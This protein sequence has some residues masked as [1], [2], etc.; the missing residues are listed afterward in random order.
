VMAAADFNVP[1]EADE[2]RSLQAGYRLKDTQR[3]HDDAEAKRTRLT[4]PRCGQGIE[5]EVEIEGTI[6]CGRHDRAIEMEPDD[7][8]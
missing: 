3:N 6:Y 2:I 4:C 7:A 8:P 1:D 5:L